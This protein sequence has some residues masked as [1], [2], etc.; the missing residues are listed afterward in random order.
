MKFLHHVLH[1]LDKNGTFVIAVLCL[2]FFLGRGLSSAETKVV[3]YSDPFFP[4]L[5]WGRGLTSAETGDR[6]RYA[7]RPDPASMG[8]RT[9][10][11]DNA[12]TRTSRRILSSGFNG[13]AELDPR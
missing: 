1:E 6:D 9:Q 3:F 5:Q 12:P 7:G 10:I 13:A 8:P 4:W 2:L 11:R